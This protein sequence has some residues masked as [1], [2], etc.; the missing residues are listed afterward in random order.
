MLLFVQEGTAERL[1]Q[2]QDWHLLKTITSP[3]VTDDAHQAYVADLSRP[4]RLTAGW[5]SS[6]C[7]AATCMPDALSLPASWQHTLVI[8]HVQR[9]E[10][11][12]VVPVS[13]VQVTECPS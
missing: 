9:G 7:H 13:A 11:N 12:D 8:V 5:V 10:R 1:L 6:P 3:G 4:G 2:A